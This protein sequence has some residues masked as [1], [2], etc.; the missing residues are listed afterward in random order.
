[1][2]RELLL[3]RRKLGLTQR[4]LAKK[5]GVSYSV[6]S[7]YERNG[8]PTDRVSKACLKVMDYIIANPAPE[9]T[10][11]PAPID[12]LQLKMIDERTLEYMI[13]TEV[14]RQLSSITIVSQFAK[15]QQ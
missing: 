9:R 11:A 2:N 1:M 10:E 13:R 15:E 12:P 6:I 14:E 5:I 8:I 3:Y 4:E 7:A